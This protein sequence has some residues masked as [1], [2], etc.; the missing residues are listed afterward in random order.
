MPIL[1]KGSKMFDKQTMNKLGINSKT[2]Y[3]NENTAV[4]L[5]SSNEKDELVKALRILD[6]QDAINR[7]KWYNLPCE[8]T[9]E[10]VERFLYYKG[11]LAFFFM[12]E[13]GKFYFMPY[14]LDGGLDFYGRYLSIHPIPYSSGQ[15]DEKTDRYK[16][17]LSILSQKK[18]SCVYDVKLPDEIDEDLVFNSAVLLHDYTKQLPQ[19][20][21]PRSKINGIFISIMSDYIPYLSTSLMMGVGIGAYRVNNDSEK[22]EVKEMSSAIYNAAI[23][24]NPYVAM[25]AKLDLQDITNPSKGRPE[26]YLMA[27]QSIDNIRLSTLGIANGGI[28]EKKAHILESE[29]A[30]NRST[31]MSAFQDGLSIRQHFCDVVNSIWG[32]E[33]WVEPSEGSL[34][35]DI[36]RDGVIYDNEPSQAAVKPI[37]GEG[38]ESDE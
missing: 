12:K 25:L 21:I 35:D 14:A 6:E 1:P 29:N 3:L 26:D 28:F 8:L 37:K 33:I 7:Y 22:D 10:E 31:V 19:N 9:S 38:G 11:Q 13:T 18:L 16:N 5:G 24:K 15:D 20:I 36:N 34:G 17:Q 4:V 30:L 27:L 32:L 23:T 2:K